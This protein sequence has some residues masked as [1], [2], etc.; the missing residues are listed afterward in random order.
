[1][2]LRGLSKR[3]RQV[4]HL[5]V[6]RDG[7]EN[8]KGYPRPNVMSIA[9]MEADYAR[10]SKEIVD[11]MLKAHDKDRGPVFEVRQPFQ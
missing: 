2:K 1:M 11:D 10:I 4:I 6:L 7:I 8:E 3:T 9:R 5:A